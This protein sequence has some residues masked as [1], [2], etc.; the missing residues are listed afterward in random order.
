MKDKSMY[1]D[2]GKTS[3][4]GSFQ[5]D[6]CVDTQMSI[7]WRCKMSILLQKYFLPNEDINITEGGT[8][9]VRGGINRLI[10]F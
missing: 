1:E 9:K 2:F 4:S 8:M 3:N 7:N 10:P 6:N 5:L